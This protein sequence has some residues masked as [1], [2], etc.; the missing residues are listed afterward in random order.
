LNYVNGKSYPRYQFSNNSD[1]IRAI[2]CSACD[3]FGVHWT[4]PSWKVIS[5]SR[6]PYVAKLDAIIGPKQ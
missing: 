4:H 3:D 6:R 5:I 2:F 1:D